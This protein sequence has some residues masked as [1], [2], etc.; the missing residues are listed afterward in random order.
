[1][2]AYCMTSSARAMRAQIIADAAQLQ[3]IPTTIRPED[4]RHIQYRPA[5]LRATAARQTQPPTNG[6][7]PRPAD[8]QANNRTRLVW[9]LRGGSALLRMGDEG[10]EARVVIEGRKIG[11]FLHVERDVRS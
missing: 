6:T 11:I 2:L 7:I 4:G 8:F 3:R 1:M 9:F 5:S 10:G